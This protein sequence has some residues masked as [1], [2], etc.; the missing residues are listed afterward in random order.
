MLF[1]D[2]P[3]ATTVYYTGPVSE[4]FLSEVEALLQGLANVMKMTGMS[5]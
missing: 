4:V 2:I 5:S 3:L 1:M